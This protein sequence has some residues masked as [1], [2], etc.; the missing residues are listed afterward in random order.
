MNLAP[1]ESL[2]HCWTTHKGQQC[3]V[4]TCK[5]HKAWVRALLS[6]T[7]SYDVCNTES[8]LTE[9][10]V[11][12]L[13]DGGRRSF[14]SLL[15]A[16]SHSYRHMWGSGLIACCRRDCATVKA[17]SIQTRRQAFCLWHVT[18]PD[19]H[20]LHDKQA[21]WCP[22]LSPS[23]DDPTCYGK[24]HFCLQRVQVVPWHAARGICEAA[25]YRGGTDEAHV[26]A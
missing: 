1:A 5:L 12:S 13:C 11:C 23:A 6:F 10:H 26:S 3:K 25:G 22:N 7:S 21:G 17:Q 19:D 24:P 20:P 2:V 14:A 16:T 4:V 9:A 18:D 8:S 15:I